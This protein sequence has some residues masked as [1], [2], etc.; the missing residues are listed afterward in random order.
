M[1]AAGFLSRYLCGPIPYVWRHITVNKNVLSTSLNKTFPSFL[2]SWGIDPMTHHTIADALPRSYISL[3]GY[4][5]LKSRFN[6]VWVGGCGWSEI[7]FCGTAS[8]HGARGRRIDPPLWDHWATIYYWMFPTWN[9]H[10][11]THTHT[12]TERERDT[13]THTHTHTNNGNNYITN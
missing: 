2:P 7:Y 8:V 4:V 12:H 13:H 5:D 1:A 3:W 11:H 10:T 6:L 9:T